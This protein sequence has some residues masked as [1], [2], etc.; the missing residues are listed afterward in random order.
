MIL[1]GFPLFDVIQSFH[2]IIRTL[3]QKI[4]GVFLD[5]VTEA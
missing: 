1:S 3:N 5:I 4:I 2:D